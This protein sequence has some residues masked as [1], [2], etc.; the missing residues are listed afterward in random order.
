MCCHICLTGKIVFSTLL[1]SVFDT[2]ILF[3]VQGD[4]PWVLKNKHFNLKERVD[5]GKSLELDDLSLLFVKVFNGE[6][7]VRKRHPI[8]GYFQVTYLH[9]LLDISFMVESPSSGPRLSHPCSSPIFT[10]VHY[11]GPDFFFV[12]VKFKDQLVT[13]CVQKLRSLTVYGS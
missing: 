1:Y 5:V 6:C 10:Y 12:K 4:L 7:G 2:H 9:V 8:L 11:N 3:S 13:M